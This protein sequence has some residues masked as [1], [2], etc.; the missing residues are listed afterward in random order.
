VVYLILV[1]ELQLFQNWLPYIIKNL[2]AITSPI[3]TQ[4][5][6][7]LV[8]NVRRDLYQQENMNISIWHVTSEYLYLHHFQHIYYAA[9]YT[10]PLK[11]IVSYA[12]RRGLAMWYT[13]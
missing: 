11:A 3:S 8:I 7:Y 4:N 2:Y 9:V 6:T 5:M 10:L 13:P 1:H 12:Y